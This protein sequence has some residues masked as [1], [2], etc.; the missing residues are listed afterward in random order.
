V[1]AQRS[2]E[3]TTGAVACCGR[4]SNEFD[5]HGG[6][7]PARSLLFASADRTAYNV[8]NIRSHTFRM[9]EARVELRTTEV[10]KHVDK[11]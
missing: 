6:C 5:A 4:S 9:A 8:G 11:S 7:V 10:W 3:R 2:K 1:P